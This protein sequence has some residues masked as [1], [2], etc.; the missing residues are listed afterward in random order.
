M[1][2]PARSD[3]GAFRDKILAQRSIVM[4]IREK[5]ESRLKTSIPE[6][7]SRLEKLAK[8]DAELHEIREANRMETES[9]VDSL[10]ASPVTDREDMPKIVTRNELEELGKQVM[11]SYKREVARID[12]EESTS[13]KK[14]LLSMY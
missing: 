9:L 4:Q 7:E 12:K 5:L 1:L 8:I 13:K 6:F 2:I 14:L 10:L 11:A 3:S